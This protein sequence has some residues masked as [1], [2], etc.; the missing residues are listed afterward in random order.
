LA[1]EV[2]MLQQMRHP[3]VIK[4]VDV[5]VA[6][7][8][9]QIIMELAE[10]GELF[11]EIVAR[12]N[13]SEKDAKEIIKK[14]LEGVSYIHSMGIVHR[15]LKPENLIWMDDP[16]TGKTTLKIIDF[17]FA[18]NSHEK[19]LKKN[20]SVGTLGYKAPE[21]M[22]SQPFS[23]KADMW[24]IGVITYI[25]LCGFPPFFSCEEYKDVGMLMNAPLW[26][27]FNEQ[28]DELV[29][30]IKNGDYSFPEVFWEKISPEAKDFVSVLLKVNTEE[31]ASAAEALEHPWIKSS[32][33]KGEIPLTNSIE[34]MKKYQQ[35]V[36]ASH[37]M[38]KSSLSET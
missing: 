2:K 1:R 26:I 27:F 21:I 34:I 18:Q 35:V 6:Q 29:S 9:L 12:K 25:L 11:E 4:L 30:A 16:A 20:T 8:A 38:S 7:E 17:G 5:Y 3:N 33:E 14:V 32:A 13:F 37:F 24:S 36:R 19:N 10:G 28:T 23:T 22:K 15:D 31:R